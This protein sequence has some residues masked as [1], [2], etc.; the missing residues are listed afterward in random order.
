VTTRGVTL[1]KLSA[2]ELNHQII[3]QSENK[4]ILI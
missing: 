1:S 3:K 2:D 4:D